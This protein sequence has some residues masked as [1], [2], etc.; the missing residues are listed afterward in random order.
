VSDI[1]VPHPPV[2]RELAA[3]EIRWDLLLM[4][5]WPSAVP[6]VALAIEALPAF[7]DDLAARLI[8]RLALSLVDVLDEVRATRALLSGALAQLHQDQIVIARH[9]R[10]LIELR[11]ARRAEGRAAA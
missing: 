11:D 6:V 8:E 3:D 2:A 7:G 5:S 4:S 10:D 1:A 9:H